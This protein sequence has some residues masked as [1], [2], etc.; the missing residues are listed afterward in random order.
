MGVIKYPCTDD[1][2]HYAYIKALK[3]CRIIITVY[4]STLLHFTLHKKYIV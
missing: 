3:E 4:I 1:S 2:V